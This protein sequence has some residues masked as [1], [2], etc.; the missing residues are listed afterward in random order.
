MARVVKNGQI[1]LTSMSAYREEPRMVRYPISDLTHDD[2]GTAAELA[3]LV[4]R[5]VAPGSWQAAG[6]QGTIQLSP[7]AL[8]ITQPDEVHHQI[9]MFCDKLRTARG[10]PPGQDPKASSLETRTSRAKAILGHVTSINIGT[11]TPLRDILERLKQPAGTEIL[12]DRPALAAAGLNENTPR[13][14][15]SEGLPQGIVLRQLLEPLGL[16]WRV[17][18]ANTLQVTTRCALAARLEVE[19]YPLSKRLTAQPPAALIEQI[20]SATPDAAWGE[21]AA[22]GAIEFDSPSHCFIV[23]Q[24]QAV[25]EAVEGFLAK[26]AK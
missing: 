1:L 4:Q 21:G 11:A 25:Q 23:R 19:F 9:A 26:G 12:I 20:K 15:R 5:F 8:R 2:A 17:V 6:G 14:L 18:N 24:T 22:A 16:G 7:D 13:T 10:L 3:R